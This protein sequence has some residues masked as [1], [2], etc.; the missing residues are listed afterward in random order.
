MTT[1]D[2]WRERRRERLRSDPNAT[3]AARRLLEEMG[4]EE[5]DDEEVE[6]DHRA[7]LLAAAREYE[8]DAHL[9]EEL[10]LRL[11]G[12]DTEGGAL[13]FQWGDSLLDPVEKAVSAAAGTPIQLELTGVSP[14]STVIHARPVAAT[15][16]QNQAALDA[17]TTSAASSG[18]QAFTRLLDALE[19]EQ[20]VREWARLFDAVDAVARALDKYELEL[21]VTWYDADGGMR[22]ARLTERGRHYVGRLR[23]TRPRDQEITISGRITEL[24]ESGWVKV[25]TGTAKNAPAYD[26]HFE[27]PGALLRMRP[28]LG[29]NVHFRVRFRQRLDSVGIARATEYTYL[30]LAA[31][32]GS[33]PLDS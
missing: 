9:E 27:D 25:K 4:T 32:Q 19:A 12:P 28:G 21:G 16:A 29:D 14:G 30:G 7:S 3:E 2:S 11:T 24:R 1:G 18:M 31:E 23:D 8:P 15:H 26:V 5:R 20:D 17:P 10:R 33:L 6:A 13:R 22:S